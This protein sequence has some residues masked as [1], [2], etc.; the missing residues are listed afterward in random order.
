MCSVN[1]IHF[2]S[3]YYISNSN[4]K[5]IKQRAFQSSQLVEFTYMFNYG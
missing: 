2:S 3:L 4:D 1:C 5:D